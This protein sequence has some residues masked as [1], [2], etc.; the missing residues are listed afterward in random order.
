MAHVQ[1][2]VSKSQR[3]FQNLVNVNPSEDV[4]CHIH[5]L[6]P[7][8]EILRFGGVRREQ[9][10]LLSYLPDGLL[11]SI[12][13]P[14]IGDGHDYYA[15][16]FYIE[17]GLVIDAGTFR[18][19]L[20]AASSLLSVEADP[21]SESLM[22]LRHLLSE[23][24]S[25]DNIRARHYPSTGHNYAYARFGGVD[26]P[27]FES[28]FKE[29]F[30]Q[31]GFS[32]YAG[33]LLIDADK[34]IDVAH[35]AHDLTSN[36]LKHIVEV[37]PPRKTASGFAALIGRRP[38]DTPMLAAEGSTLE[39]E[40]RRGGFE[41]V[42]ESYL[43]PKGGGTPPVPDTATARRVISPSTFYIT[44]QGS[45][46]SVGAYIVRVNGIEIDGPKAFSYNELK[47]AKVEISSPG[48]FAFSGNIDLASSSQALVQMRVLHKTYRFDLPLSAPEPVE[49]VRI[50]LKTKNPLTHCPIEGYDIAGDGMLE[51]SG[52]T[53]RLVYVGGKGRYANLRLAAIVLAALLAGIIAG[54]YLFP[55]SSVRKAAPVEAAVVAVVDPEKTT[56]SVVEPESVSAPV[57]VVAD[58]EA[59]AAYLDA[60]R[61]WTRDGLS[62]I[63]GFGELYD[64]INNYNFER[65]E[66]YWAS[67]LGDKSA[68]FDK[69]L[70]AVEGA[71]HKR[72]PRVELHTPT[73]APAD[74]PSINWRSY[75]YWIDP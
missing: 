64:D 67:L 74:K 10:Y 27:A 53:N 3:G 59:A 8:L 40:W 38:F 32:S 62:G 57:E 60:N 31:P 29:H 41:P 72:D 63:S 36:P 68:N 16:T 75:T 17:E 52:V 49:A 66:G 7:A 9:V 21:T 43:V 65:L 14:M 54:R 70:K 22:P 15:A 13:Q 20:G 61:D 24:F 47:D 42:H 37:N 28:Y 18:S 35:V 19:L 73:Y 34:D 12:I 69:V 58:V 25:H 30:Y 23:D 2:Y 48:Y 55:N 39:I 11:F 4:V 5:D 33:V 44:E 50:Y 6:S 45:Q 1:L 26:A 71:R 51:G 46:R 56:A